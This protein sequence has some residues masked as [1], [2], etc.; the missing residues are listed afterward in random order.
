MLVLEM[1]KLGILA[2]NESRRLRTLWNHSTF[3]IGGF[4]LTSH[5]KY[6]SEPFIN[7]LESNGCPSDSDTMGA[8]RKGHARELK[9]SFLL[10]AVPREC[11][12]SEKKHKKPTLGGMP[13]SSRRC[14]HLRLTSRIRESFRKR[15]APPL[16]VSVV[17][18]QVTILPLSSGAGWNTI[19]DVVTF[20]STDVC[21]LVVETTKVWYCSLDGRPTIIRSRITNT[22]RLACSA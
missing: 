4:A 17:I 22:Y 8:S 12:G 11:T 18:E 3:L 10:E 5:S 20:P 2:Q 15:P 19:S 6:T 1:I 16:S 13:R 9:V 21:E 7:L 14:S